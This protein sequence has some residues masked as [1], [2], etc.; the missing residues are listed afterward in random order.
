V[1]RVTGVAYAA[2]GERIITGGSD[3]LI[4]IWDARRRTAIAT[5]VASPPA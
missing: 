4:S 2:G 1:N 5:V 3:G